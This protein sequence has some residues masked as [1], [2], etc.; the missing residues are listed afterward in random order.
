VVI[1]PKPGK[2]DLMKLSI[3]IDRVFGGDEEKPLAS[4]SQNKELLTMDSVI[5]WFH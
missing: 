4:C 3:D 5:K 2:E 1:L